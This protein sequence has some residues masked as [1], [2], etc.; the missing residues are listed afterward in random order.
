M[1]P[2]LMIF[3]WGILLYLWKFEFNFAAL[4][5]FKKKRKKF[6]ICLQSFWTSEYNRSE[7]YFA[8]GGI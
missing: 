7:K 5:P 1:I 3:G 2:C 8:E 4:H 6:F